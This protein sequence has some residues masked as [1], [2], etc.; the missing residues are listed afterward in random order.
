MLVPRNHSLPENSKMQVLFQTLVSTSHPSFK[1][2][3]VVTSDTDTNLPLTAG[4]FI[5]RSLILRAS[6]P[7]AVG[8]LSEN[9]ILSSIFITSVCHKTLTL[10]HTRYTFLCLAYCP[11]MFS[12]EDLWY[13]ICMENHVSQHAIAPLPKQRIVISQ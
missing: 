10:T 13:Q 11:L 4:L 1:N 9:Y 6:S 5:Q 7:K 2:F 12:G 3:K 8:Q